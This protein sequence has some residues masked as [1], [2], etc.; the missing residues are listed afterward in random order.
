MSASSLPLPPPRSAVSCF[1]PTSGLR[2]NLGYGSH[3]AQLNEL[4]DVERPTS[5]TRLAL[6]ERLEARPPSMAF[7]C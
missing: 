3:L 2:Q 1:G 7:A 4:W 6:G 5:R